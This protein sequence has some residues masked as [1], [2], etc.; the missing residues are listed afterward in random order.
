MSDAYTKC[1]HCVNF[2][3]ENCPES[4][5][6]FA[7]NYKPFYKAKTKLRMKKKHRRAVYFTLNSIILLITSPLFLLSY[8][9]GGLTWVG[10]KIIVPPINWLKT[11]LRVYDYDPD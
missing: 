2:G 9:G 1:K 6:C 8:F 10:N 7:L 11:K 3:T 4:S 5:L